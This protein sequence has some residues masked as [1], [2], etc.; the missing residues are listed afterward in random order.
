MKRTADISHCGRYRYS[1]TR[2]WDDARARVLFIMLNPSTAD[3]TVD[4]PTIRRCIGFA[5]GWGFGSLE[6][7][8]LSPIRSS[9]PSEI[10][11]RRTWEDGWAYHVNRF[12]IINAAERAALVIYAWGAHK[13]VTEH[14]LDW[15]L[16]DT[17][18]LRNGYF[19]H[20]L[21]EKARVIGTTKGG[22]PRHPLYLRRDA[23]PVEW[24]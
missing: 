1:L 3:A 19:R 5:C 8:N 11:R 15:Y 18:N 9:D 22:A 10:L 6:V 23:V 13:A 24:K 21:Y 4:D 16:F 12:A 2:E 20:H 14:H 17:S 7:V